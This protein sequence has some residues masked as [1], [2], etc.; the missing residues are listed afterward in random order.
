M[1]RTKPFTMNSSFLLN[2]CFQLNSTLIIIF[3]IAIASPV[4]GQEKNLSISADKMEKRILELAN[5]GKN[6]EGHS[7]RVAFSEADLEARAYVMEEM[8]KAGLEVSVDFAGNIIGRRKGKD[9][10]RPLIAFGSHI[11]TVPDGGNYDGCVGSMAGLEIMIL[12]QELGIQTNHPLELIIFSNEEGG[13]MGSRALAGVLSAQA[14]K[15]T[16]STGYSME[17][18]ISRLG[19]DPKRLD[20]IVRKPG[21]LAVF[22]ELHIEQGGILEQKNLDIGVVEGIVGINWWDVKV[23]GFANHAGTTPM[24]MRKDALL[25]ASQFVL[26]V[27]EVT[28]SFEGHQVGT[29]GMIEAQPGAPNVI[30]GEVNMSLEIRDLSS[31]KILK[32]YDE[33]VKRAE[34]IAEKYHV[35]FS[36]SPTD[37][38]S[39]PALTDEGLRDLI[40]ETSK[41]LG[42]SSMRMQSGAGH[43]AQD[44]AIIAPTGMIFV[45]SKGG[46]SHSPKEFTSAEDMANGAN[47]LL[48]TILE[49]DKKL[50]K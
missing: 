33:M 28:N 2:S 32:M 44:M 48:Q 5:Y 18:G 22:L 3:F 19:G 34:K 10:D 42:H 4:S 31:E 13:V 23:S 49:L 36:F 21:D 24:D 1:K 11:D 12:L 45:P 43:D 14:L 39:K 25:A 16:N 29:V 50:V 38:T 47:V 27:N 41:A 8:K 37:A 17:E 46:I 15:V 26:M 7:T 6:A 30:P 20:E 40:E 35:E 9:D